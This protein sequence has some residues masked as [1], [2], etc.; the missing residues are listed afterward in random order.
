LWRNSSQILDRRAAWAA[1]IHDVRGLPANIHDVRGLPA[2]IHDVRGLPACSEY[3]LY[4]ARA[5]LV[6]Y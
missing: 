5:F 1:N 4:L 2:N 3:S 6:A